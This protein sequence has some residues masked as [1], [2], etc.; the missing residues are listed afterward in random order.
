MRV[1]LKWNSSLCVLSYFL[2]FPPEK[3]FIFPSR[4][5]LRNTQGFPGS[6][7]DKESACNVGDPG[8]IPGSDTQFS[9]CVENASSECLK[10]GGVEQTDRKFSGMTIFVS[11]FQDQK[12]GLALTVNPWMTHTWARIAPPRILC[13]LSEGNTP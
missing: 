2:A 6:S 3:F 8:S 9:S 7:V 10:G 13:C 1:T 11:E 5:L 4:L 12:W